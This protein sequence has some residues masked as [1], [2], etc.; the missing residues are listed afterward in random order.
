MRM[1]SFYMS[2]ITN[3]VQNMIRQFLFA[4]LLPVLLLPAIAKS[5]PIYYNIAHAVNHSQYIDWALSQ[6]ANAVEA[7]LRFSPSGVV[8]KFQHGTMCECQLA[9]KYLG[10]FKRQHQHICGEMQWENPIYLPD[11]D[12]L[13]YRITKRK[14]TIRSAEDACMVNERADLYLNTLATKN[15]AL[16]IV[17]SKI[18]NS[19]VDTDAAKADAG[20][21]VIAHLIKHLFEKGYPGKVIVGVDK[22]DHSAYIKAAAAEAAKSE[23]YKD[24]IY[25][26]FDDTKRDNFFSDRLWL[27]KKNPMDV[28][29]NL[30]NEYAKGKAVYGNGISSDLL[31]IG[32]FTGTFKDSVEAEKQGR[33]QL[34][35]IWTLDSHD[36]MQ[37]FLALGVRGI[38]TN[39]PI[40]LQRALQPYLANGARMARPEDPLRIP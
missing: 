15:I 5:E 22:I 36:S 32:G 9:H 33:V 34:N 40:T 19:K 31:V 28:A 35:Y 10:V 11:P 38:M 30:L 8:T 29:I 21:A 24:R 4:C 25:F 18:K 6:G 17:D 37:D 3:P 16:F 27:F 14:E 12:S 13:I 23:K 39:K 1:S 7:D 2:S 20:R 26:S